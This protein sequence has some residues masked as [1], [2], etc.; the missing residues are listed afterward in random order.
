[1]SISSSYPNQG[2]IVV[3]TGPSSGINYTTILNALNQSLSEP[4]TLM[5]QQETPLNNQLSAWQTISADVS[6]LN[7]AAAALGQPSLFQTYTATSSNTSVATATASS[8]AIPGTYALSVTS[9]ATVDVVA[10]Q[11]VASSSANVGTGTFGITVNGTTTNINITSSNDTLSG[12]A[13]AI[14]NSS[15]AAG[16]TAS[17]INNGGSTNPYQL[18]LTSNNTG[19]NNA[20]SVTDGLTGGTALTFTTTQAAA[21]AALTYGGINITSQSNTVKNVIPGVTLNLLSTGSTTVTVGLDTQAIDSSANSFVTA[22]NK[23]ISDISAQ[24]TVTSSGSGNTKNSSL[25]PLGGNVALSGLANTL[26]GFM[27]SEA[28]T[29]SGSAGLPSTYGITPNSNGSGQLQLNTTTLNGMLTSNPQQVQQFLSALMNGSSTANGVS[30][31]GGL[32]NYL[33]TYTNPANGVFQFSE[34]QINTQ[35]TNMN[36]QIAQMQ[37]NVQTQMGMYTKEFSNLES[38]IGQMQTT[39]SALAN[40]IKQL[41]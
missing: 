20:I 23:L 1:M 17:I 38:Y 7:S 24:N 32:T 18:V 40:S 22:Y 5:Q 26:Y 37:A 3:G 41:P 28:P 19:T 13:Q 27:G 10:S 33:N 2:L 4:I 12:L 34:A 14:N 11:G 31:P 9:L 35:L 21:N 6:A 25:G 36:N 16:V 39:N 8:S 29:L 30:E 15:S